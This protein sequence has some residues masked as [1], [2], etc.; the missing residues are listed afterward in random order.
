MSPLFWIVYAVCAAI[1]LF[2]FVYLWKDGSRIFACVFTGTALITL[3]LFMRVAYVLFHIEEN[4][5][6][7][8]YGG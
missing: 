8:G 4:L 1:I 2:V 5:I 3:Y 7:F 6:K